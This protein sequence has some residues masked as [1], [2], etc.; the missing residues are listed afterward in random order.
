MN[1]GQRKLLIGKLPAAVALAAAAFAFSAQAAEDYK[2]V[3]AVSVTAEAL[4]IDTSTEET[5][6]TVN[7]I[8]HEELDN[9]ILRKVDDALRYTPGFVNPYGA[10]YDSNWIHMRGFEVTT[11]IDGQ[12][13]Y[14]EGFFD[15]TVEPFGLE[16]IE[17]ISGP[18]S[19]LYGDSQPGGIVNLV[20]K[21]PT[22]T[23]QHSVTV[24]AGTQKFIQGGLDISDFASEDG[25][26][27]YRLVAMANRED[28]FV[29]DVDGWRAYIAPS[30]TIDISEKTSLTLLASYLKDKKTPSNAFMLAFGTVVPRNGHM[31]PYGTNYGD[32]EHDRYDKDQVS[33][34]WEF[35][36]VFND[37]IEYKQSF[38]AK[39]TD[40]FL[41]STAAYGSSD[42]TADY[43]APMV[44]PAGLYR[45]TLLNDGTEVSFTFDNNLTGKW[46]ANDFDSIVQVG[47]DYQ[48][49]K[50]KWKGNG[51][52]VA[53][54]DLADPFHPSHTGM[55]ADDEL[56]VWNND[57]KKQQLGLY[58][59]AQT[60]WN[61]T[62]LLKG[63][64]RYDFVKIDATNENPDS[65]NAN[66]SLDDGQLS[67]NAGVMYFGPLGVSPYVNYSEAFYTNASMA[68]VG[69][70]LPKT[71][72]YRI[73]EPIKTK[74][75]EAGVKFTPDWLDGYVNLAWFRLKQQ[76][77]LAQAVLG[78][79][80]RQA[81]V[82]EKES[83]GVEIQMQAAL[84]KSLI[85]NASYTYQEVTKPWYQD[86]Y[87]EWHD[88]AELSPKHLASA[89][90]SYNFA[91]FGLPQLTIGNGIRYL[92][93]TRDTYTQFKV[94]SATL[95]DANVVYEFNRNWKFV[96]TASNITDHRYVAGSDWQ[97]AYYGEGRVVRGSL[98][99][100]W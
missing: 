71:F 54:K 59:Q 16:A 63:G 68:Q 31:I 2:T 21:K 6:Q 95:W 53:F 50:N 88:E 37:N 11:L 57:I 44:N 55:P 38:T 24:T 51:N 97:T 43:S 87:K 1:K 19:S 42:V 36:H 90:V 99:Y 15:T 13:Q 83:T 78:G 94:D 47:F 74:Q 48:H 29:D 92:G 4:K 52:G 32:P 77:A 66:D 93:S 20:T 100:N 5:P 39:Y 84:T 41:R 49:H 60:T 86:I 79:I 61:E 65:L 56:L 26:K 67:W 35:K 82:A 7:V 8:S 75:I 3:E 96:G 14:K 25:S 89:W 91:D 80:P 62:L 70:Y 85:L 22:K 69:G 40:L 81:Q 30:F 98:S 27:R 45:A 9:K 23:P 34:G 10:D 17:V 12:T 72:Q 28:S 76:N 58:T 33:F 18:A 46:Y 64:L 73:Y